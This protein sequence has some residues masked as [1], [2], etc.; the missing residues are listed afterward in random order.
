MGLSLAAE[1][2]G[3]NFFSNGT[4]VGGI[5]EYDGAMSDKAFDRFKS[6]VK[7]NY[8]GLG[9][10]NRLIFLEQGAKFTA[11]N[12]PPDKAQFL[13]TR[14]FQVIE[15]CRFF[16]VPPHMIMD[17]ER[18][19]FSN[20]EQQSIGYVVYSLRPWLVCIE[21]SAYKDLLLPNQQ[22]KLF[23]KFNVDALLRGD[24]KTRMEG[25]AISRQNGW[26]NANDIRELEDMN[27]IPDDQGGNIYLVNGNM[28]TALQASEQNKGG[29]NNAGGN[30]GNGV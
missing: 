7:D 18:A 3:E 15:I 30:Q 21:Q 12:T 4:N 9:K 26:L 28:L 11:V 13:D 6:D 17:L 29:E 8:E 2:F 14:K 20:I 1:E 5:V 22:K 24:F 23:F 27:P 19:T 25:Y 16:N 10:S